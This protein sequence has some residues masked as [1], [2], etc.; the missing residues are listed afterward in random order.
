MLKRSVVKNH[1][2]AK[3]KV[4]LNQP[5]LETI[6]KEDPVTDAIPSD[7]GFASDSIILK[8]DAIVSMDIL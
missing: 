2:K 8:T 5:S 7:V 4:L 6:T 3:S 1:S